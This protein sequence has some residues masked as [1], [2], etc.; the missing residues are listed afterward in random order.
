MERDETRDRGPR[1]SDWEHTRPVG[2]IV[3]TLVAVIAWLVFILL[4]ALFWS[5]NYNLF[6]NI[7]V[8]VVTLGITAVVIALGWVIWGFR[9]VKHWMGPGQG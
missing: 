4:Y 2:G 1:Y 8:T 6:Q 3:L 7:V 5:G 9:N